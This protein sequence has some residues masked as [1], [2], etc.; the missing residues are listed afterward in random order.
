MSENGLSYDDLARRCAAAEQALAEME[1]KYRVITDNSS[2]MITLHDVNGIYQYASPACKTLLGYEPEELVGRNPYDLFH[3]DDIPQ[4]QASH[5]A[6]LDGKPYTIIFRQRGK[7]GV[8]RWLETNNRFILDDEGQVTGIICLTRDISERKQAEEKLFESEEKFRAIFENNSAAIAIIEYD[9][10]ISMVNDAYCKM[11]GYS[12]EEIIGSS[13]TRQIPPEDLERL[14]EYN[15]RRLI[16]PQDAPDEYE[17]TFYNKCGEIRQAVISLSVVESIKKIIAAF[18]DITERKQT[19]AKLREMAQR[20][21]LAT[22]SAK[23]GIWEWDINANT[24]SWDDRM[25]EL[26]GVERESFPST[27]E[28][29]QHGLHPDDMETALEATRAARDGERDYDTEF[30]VVHPNGTV[31]TLKANAVVLRDEQG[32]PLRMI[33]LNYDITEQKNAAEQ[34]RTS[35]LQYRQ[36][37]QN[38]PDITIFIY[39]HDFRFTL[40]E[41]NILPQIGYENEQLLGKTYREV[42]SP[43]SAEHLAP[44]YKAALEGIEQKNVGVEYGGHFYNV[45]FVSIRDLQGEI[46][47]GMVVS[48]DITERKLAELA[49]V[50]SEERFRKLFDEVQTIAVQGYEMDGTVKYWNNASEILYGYT[51]EEAIG[52]NLLDLIIPAEM[53]DGVAGAIEHMQV[54]GEVISASE[55]TL[56]HKNGSPVQ[57]YSSHALVQRS[58]GEV[59]LFC[60]D[61]D[62]SER[63]QAEEALRASE[64]E[65]RLLIQ[66]LHAGVVVHAPDT[67]ILL[68]NDQA[69]VL[70]GLSCDQMMGKAAIDPAWC[71]IHA[72]ESPM[73]LDEYPVNRVLATNEPL[74]NLELGIKRSSGDQVWVLVNAFP[75]FTDAGDIRQVVVTF[76]DITERKQAE[77]ALR[78]SQELIEGI[79]NAMPVSVFWK[80]KDLHYLGC[81][82]YFALDAGYSDPKE[83]IGKDDFQMIWRELAEKY[84]ADDR[85]I[86]ESGCAKFNI[87]EPNTTPSGNAT[88]LTSKLPLRDAMGE[89]CGILGTYMDITERKQV[90]EALRSSEERYRSIFNGITEGFA[91]HEI[92]C[93]ADGKPCDYRF[94]EINPSFESLT[95]L[96][97]NVVIGKLQS[98]VLPAEDPKWVEMY[99]KVALTGEPCQFDNYSTVLEKHFEVY[100]YSPAPRQ[101]AVLFLDITERKQAEAERDRLQAQ[102]EQAH[103]MESVGRLAGGVAHDFNNM[104]GVIMGYTELALLDA[105]PASKLHANLHEIQKASER[106]A[107]LTRQLLAFARKQTVSPKVLDMNDTISGMLKMLRRLIGEDIDLS[108]IPGDD[109]WAVKIDPSQVDQ[110]LANLCVNARDAI[111]G[112]GKVTIETTNILCDEVY[113]A[114]NVGALPGDYVM[115]V[116]SDNGSGIDAEILG[117]IFEPFYTT[118]EVGA[119]TGLGLA[120]V[121]GAVI[122][123]GG[124]INVYSEPGQGTSFKIFLPRYHAKSENIVADSAPIPLQRGKETILLVEDE[125]AILNLGKKALERHGY[126]VI[127]AATPGE[128]ISK[129]EEYGGEIHL[130][131]TDV[132]MPEMNGRDLARHLIELYPN[133]KR[134]F[135]SGYTADVIAHHGVLE[136]GVNFLQKPFTIQD[137]AAKVRE[138]LDQ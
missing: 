12:R 34:L 58:T 26:Y 106:S 77:E 98:E 103:K 134:L 69:A 68:A 82:S 117:H 16:N 1:K 61:I 31:K 73:P 94:L 19:D 37:A 63:K 118:K 66:N 64:L 131:L 121:Y 7:D 39:D 105:D 124:F 4:V 51:A 120:T 71:F 3:P 22:S 50:E 85:Q 11:S 42:L 96:Q 136:D 9:T 54:T 97:R 20:L 81:N 129:A 15:H 44:Y 135:M 60:I 78:A 47:A 53:R 35:E 89:I 110:M 36:L 126:Q 57:V 102:L 138:V 88:V 59:E 46:V 91:L 86:M 67:Q 75:N 116:V 24:L 70:L 32:T 108:W 38:L 100:A 130:L 122:Q 41:G 137:L 8:Y 132:I 72:D 92:V 43:E 56:K 17:F 93:D 128:A 28:A 127:T 5:I 107:D 112:V 55:L 45:D 113:C 74:R 49:L 21:Q 27:F 33:G 29:W 90:E 2:D 13:W 109:L 40:V 95:G 79:I 80:D 84:R 6:V 18:T 133:I 10:T 101:F 65:Q 76:V 119:G 62:I 104:L 52:H 23:L 99:G 87:E 83:V 48:R 30:R 111:N 115:L 125:P 25:Y 123:N 114:Q 14:K